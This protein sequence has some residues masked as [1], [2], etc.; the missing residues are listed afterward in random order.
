MELSLQNILNEIHL[1]Q[2]SLANKDSSNSNNKKTSQELLH[3]KLDDAEE[4]QKKKPKKES[5]LDSFKNKFK[6][7]GE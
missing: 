7:K 4:K 3:K 2:D 6:G 1:I 5:K